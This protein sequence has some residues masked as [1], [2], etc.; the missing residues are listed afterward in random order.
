MKLATYNIWNDERGGKVRQRQVADEIAAAQADV[1]GLQEVSPGLFHERLAGLYPYAAFR[2]YAGE[3]E[4]LAVL[5]RYPIIETVWLHEMPEHGRSA[6]LG[7]IVEAAGRR[8]A[9][10]NLHLPWDSAMQKEKQIVAIDRFMRG[11]EAENRVL[12]GDFNGGLNSSVHRFLLG[13]QTLLGCEANPCWYELGSTWTAMYGQPLPPTL[14]FL[15]NPRWGGRNS[16]EIPMAAD[17][18]YVMRHDG[19]DKLRHVALFGT[20]VSPESG[21]AASDH[22]GVVAEAEFG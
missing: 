8:I 15:R 2:V 18:I 13:E 1:I 6:A 5:S 21:Y 16:T 11:W 17:R 4:G 10:T 12:L 22:Y 7:V 19:M 9:V 3:D 20:T 14:D